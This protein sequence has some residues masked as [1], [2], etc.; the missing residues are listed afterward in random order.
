MGVK[1]LR[2]EGKKKMGGV[3]GPQVAQQ[4]LYLTIVRKFVL[5]CTWL[6]S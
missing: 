6:A 2:F 3:L 4:Q 5:Y 1:E